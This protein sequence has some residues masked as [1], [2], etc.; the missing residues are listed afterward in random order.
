[1]KIYIRL[2]RGINLD[3]NLNPYQFKVWTEN[4]LKNDK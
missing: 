3:T 4:N 2:I 1:M